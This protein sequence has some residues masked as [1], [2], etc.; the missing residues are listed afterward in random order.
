MTICGFHTSS[1]NGIKRTNNAYLIRCMAP[2][3]CGDGARLLNVAVRQA[4]GLWKL[5]IVILAISGVWVFKKL[6]RQPVELRPIRTGAADSCL[7]F[8]YQ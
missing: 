5:R 3:G 7:K 8:P 2:P 6:A 4:P 1:D